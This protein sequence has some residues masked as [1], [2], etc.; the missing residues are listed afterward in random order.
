MRGFQGEEEGIMK[1]KEI[2]TSRPCVC[3]STDSVAEVARLMRDN[4]CG[5]IPIVDNGCV[6]GIVTDRDLAIRAIAEGRSA[7]TSVGEVMTASPC[8]CTSD[9]DIADVEKAMTVN[10]VR[11]IPIVDVEG[12]CLGIV[13]Q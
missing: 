13:S 11:R 7:D 4:D 5:A 1:A 8:C 9:D 6:V 2:M 12:C 3:T 10:Q